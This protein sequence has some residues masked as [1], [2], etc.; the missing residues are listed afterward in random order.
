[1]PFTT[2]TFGIYKPN[3]GTIQERVRNYPL[4][5]TCIV[6]LYC[7]IVNLFEFSIF[8]QD[9]ISNQCIQYTARFYIYLSTRFISIYLLFHKNLIIIT[10]AH[11]TFYFTLATFS[12]LSSGGFISPRIQVQTFNN[13]LC[14]C[15]DHEC[16]CYLHL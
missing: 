10:Y 11:F 1:M 2:F 5:L 13:M 16:A 6:N 7:L 14:R 9:T 8:P 12:I 4:D 3:I 15:N